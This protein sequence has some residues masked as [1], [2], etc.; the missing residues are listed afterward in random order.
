MKQTERFQQWL[1][2][3]H[4]R[5]VYGLFVKFAGAWRESGKD[6]CA[7][8]LVLNRIRWEMNIANP[9][10]DGYKISNNVGPMMA[11]HLALTDPSYRHFFRFHGDDEEDDALAVLK[12]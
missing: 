11:R 3:P 1:D 10:P 12:A 9:Y 2:S 8:V 6:K 7:F 5:E 4:G